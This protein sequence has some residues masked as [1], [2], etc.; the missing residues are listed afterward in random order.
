MGGFFGITSREDCM[1]DVFFGVDYHSHLG[2]RRGGMAAYDREIG[3]QR[4]IHNIEN[5]P[6]RTKFEHI[7][8]EME[9]TSVIGCISDSDPQPMLIRSNLGTY[10]ICTVG[11][12]N[13]A[14]ALIDR[15][16]SFSGGHF[17][18]MTG[19]RVNTTELVAALIDQ[20]SS[21]S[22]GIRFAQNSIEGTANI[23]ILKENGNIIAARDKLGRIPVQIG[24]NENGYCASL[25]EFAFTKLG[26]EKVCELGPGEIVELT[27]E[28]MTR[29]VAPGKDMRICA[30]LWSYYGYPTSTYEGINVEAMRYRNGAAIAER[31]MEQGRSMDI[32]YVGGVPDSGTPHAIG[33]ANRTGRPFARAFIKYTPTWARSFTPARQSDRKKIAKMKQIPVHD[34]IKDKNLLFVDDSIVRGTQLRET[35]EF[36][37]ENGAKSVHMRSACPP[38]MYGCKYLNFSRST[39]DLDLITRRVILELEGEEGMKHL[40]EYADGKTERGKAMRQAICDKFNFASLGFQSLEGVVNAIG[41]EP[42]KLCT[43]CWT[44]KE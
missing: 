33:Y 4:K 6:F 18:A 43:Y 41:L 29:L 34:L 44:G 16:L 3:L 20:K 40:E 14:D 22:D 27:P 38:I 1:M 7:F 24:K 35:V 10:A 5:A 37:Y 32:D 11:I 9:G 12:I 30:F 23:L 25:E 13:N 28:S 36:L 8:S 31:D 39:S 2:T 21:F 26:Y 19:G 17:D 15:Y 42:C